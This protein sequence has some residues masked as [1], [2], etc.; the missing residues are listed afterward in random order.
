MSK[1]FFGSCDNL[2]VVRES[3]RDKQ[4]LR[5]RQRD[6]DRQTDRDR[7][8]QTETEIQ[9]DREITARKVIVYQRNMM[10]SVYLQI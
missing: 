2:H 6:R 9:R 3:E 5:Q 1:E 10:A 8:R 4:R 7:Q